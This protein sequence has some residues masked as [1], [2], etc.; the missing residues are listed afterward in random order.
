MSKPNKPGELRN[1]EVEAISLVSK[2]ANREK[3][4]IFKS[5]GEEPE[6]PDKSP[7]TVTNDE[8]GLF[9]IL[10]EFFTGEKI[11][12]GEV[13]NVFN[14]SNHGEELYKAFQAFLQVLGLSR[15]NDDK[16]NPETDPVKIT[17][18]VDDF[19]NVAIGILLGKKEV[20]K[21]GR[22]ISGSRLTKLKDIQTML[23]DVLNGLE[24]NK[25]DTELTKEE[26]TKA[27]EDALKPITERIE[28]LEAEPEQPAVPAEPKKDESVD[29]AEVVKNS[30]GEA[31]APLTERIEKIEKARGFSNKVPEETQIEK[32]SN[33]FWGQIF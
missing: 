20:E 8:R 5:A 2:A 15:W 9:Q 13:A 24:E 22:K 30:I 14:A 26:V 23:N 4:K 27:V 12:K 6:K 7:K 1:V 19:R 11:E 25:E 21:S 16:Q 31:I 10:K 32:D 28:K 29:V 17:A 3:F 33:D 18:A